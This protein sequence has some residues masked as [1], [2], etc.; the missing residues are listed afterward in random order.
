M[1][2]QR[3]SF[4][5]PKGVTQ[6]EWDTACT[7]MR[8]GL[9]QRARAHGVVTYREAPKLA[10]NLD[11]SNYPDWAIKRVQLSNLLDDVM[12]LTSDA[13]EPPLTV[14]VVS[15]VDWLPS[16]G[17]FISYQHF[18]SPTT[19]LEDIKQRGAELAHRSTRD[20]WKYWLK[21]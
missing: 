12:R 10:P 5:P 1:A 21:R 17:F 20:C 18:Y 16:E 13:D 4:T 14:L 2:N 11:W 19:P 15:E 8:F 9:T 6:P 3:Q 7:T